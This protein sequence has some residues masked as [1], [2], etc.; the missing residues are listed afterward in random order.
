MYKYVNASGDTVVCPKPE[1]TC[2]QPKHLTKKQLSALAVSK[3]V[4]IPDAENN[5]NPEFPITETEEYGDTQFMTGKY[6]NM[7][8]VLEEEIT[9]KNVELIQSFFT[10]GRCHIYAMALQSLNPELILH[11]SIGYDED[12]EEYNEDEYFID[13]VYCVD[14]ITG[15]AYDATGEY[16][17]EEDLLQSNPLYYMLERDNFST[18]VAG[19]KHDM[20]KNL[21]L[22]AG[23]KTIELAYKLALKNITEQQA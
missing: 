5:S 2:W 18:D 8:E 1:G 4:T 12:E 17:S 9:D 11:V 23:E 22:P 6:R 14:Y 16:N 19:L 15:K 13:H 3:T 7:G 21:L 20:D 10:Q